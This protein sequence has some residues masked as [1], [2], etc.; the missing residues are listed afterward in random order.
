MKLLVVGGEG[1][2]GHVVKLY[3]K[4]KGHIVKSTSRSDK[5]DF[6]FDATKN[7]TNLEKYIQEFKPDVVINCIGILNQTAEDNKSLA[8]LVNSYLPHYLDELCIKN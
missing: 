1:M 5:G 8:V 4:E 6:V 2:L 3:F 7:L